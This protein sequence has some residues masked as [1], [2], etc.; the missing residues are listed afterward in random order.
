M[1]TLKY[2]AAYYRQDD[3]WYVADVL[4]FPGALSQGRTLKE[5]KWMIR[6]ALKL[7]AE[8]MIEEGQPLPKPNLRARDKNADLVET[9]PL[10]VRV[11]AGVLV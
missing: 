2:H 6:D 1:T 7:L 4:D 8:C 3:G 10:R 5:A 9:I 11:S